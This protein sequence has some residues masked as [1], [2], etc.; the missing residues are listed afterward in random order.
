MAKD[1]TSNSARDRDADRQLAKGKVT[2]HR[3][4]ASSRAWGKPENAGLGRREIEALEREN[5]RGIGGGRFAISGRA[6]RARG[7]KL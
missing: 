4:G 1:K 3:G 5:S 7:G 2:H 6:G